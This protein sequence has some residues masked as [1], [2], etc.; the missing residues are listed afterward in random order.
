[1]DKIELEELIINA[2]NAG[3]SESVEFL[4]GE[5]DRL[6]ST[7]EKEEKSTWDSIKGGLASAPINAYLGGK[8]LINGGL[9]DIDKSILMQNREAEK[10]A[11]V[12]SILSNVA[13]MAIPATGLV[14]AG[15]YAGKLGTALANPANM[16]QA[17]AGGAVYGGIQPT[18]E[19][20][21]RLLN[22]GVGGV[23]GTLGYGVGKLAQKVVRPI[24]TS[25]VRPQ[26]TV[27]S[28][29]MNIP[30]G[31]N[32]RQGLSEIAS[33]EGIPLSAADKTGSKVLQNIN[34]AM[35]N[36]PATA[37]RVAEEQA[38]KQAAF[39]KAVLKKVGI[40]A[41]RATPDVLNAQY[42]SLGNKF[43]ELVKR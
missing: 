28:L 1:V 25:V 41:D 2:D 9:S 3:D 40:D 37:G 33:R 20:E 32:V 42:S 5:L 39:N 27:D 19:D 6:K 36:I 30:K 23:G 35:A 10:D 38:L 29:G 22:V 15:G 31:S 11:P 4:L 43:E 13:T 8:Q 14:K 7:P 17:T 18:M 24:A 34:A 26:D 16:A 12:S 21:S